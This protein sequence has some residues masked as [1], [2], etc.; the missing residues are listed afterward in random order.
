[1]RSFLAR[2]LGNSRD[3]SGWSRDVDASRISLSVISVFS[4]NGWG[5]DSHFGHRNSGATGS[6]WLEC[7][8]S[9]E[10][11]AIYLVIIVTPFCRK[12]YSCISVLFALHPHYCPHFTICKHLQ[13]S[14]RVLQCCNML[15]TYLQCLAISSTTSLTLLQMC[16]QVHHW[17][18]SPKRTSCKIHLP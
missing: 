5:V 18:L 11:I 12:H 7:T 16:A 13:D 6:R 8:R 9:W 2:R 3:R 17:S 14:A 4:H 15:P 1:M 10:D